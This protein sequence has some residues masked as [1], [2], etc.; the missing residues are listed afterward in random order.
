MRSMPSVLIAVFLIAVIS[1]C[2]DNAA[3]LEVT[4][5]QRQ[6]AMEIDKI[7][8]LVK[9]QNLAILKLRKEIKDKPSTTNGTSREKMI[10]A[11]LLLAQSGPSNVSRQA[12]TILGYLGGK[13]A[14]N[15]LL[16]MVDSSSFSRNY[17]S[18]TN[19]LINM[20]SSKVRELLLKCLKS[21]DTNHKNAAMNILRNRSLR[22]LKK[23]DL[24]MLSTI[25]DEMPNNNHNR[26]NRNN[27]IGVICRL[28][29]ETGVKHI[30]DALEE[31]TDVNQQR[32]LLYI[33]NNNRIK[34]RPNLLKKIIETLGEPDSQ[35]S[36]SFQAL[37]GIISNAGDPRL[38][39][40][41]LPWADI[42]I[43]NNNLKSQYLNMLHRM[44][45]PKAAKTMLELSSNGSRNDY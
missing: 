26:Y 21:D 43:T 11:A 16:K 28:D 34:L 45:D 40:S 37:F 15:A 42:V 23:S 30:C 33:L 5:I 14:E 38:T 2:N 10:Q 18:I 29:Q 41:V 19:A 9:Q 24:P 13:E 8:E 3:L 31:I 36:N 20:R 27:L 39:D 1:G 17:S 12:I 44:R 4:K 25:L 32:E 22:I 6:Q 7:I 35:N